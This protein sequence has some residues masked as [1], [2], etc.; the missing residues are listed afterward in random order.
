M[1]NPVGRP[2]LYS[3]ETITKTREYID[4]CVDEVVAYDKFTKLKVKIPTIE[5]LAVH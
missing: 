1:A 3:A 2:T 5:G 4:S